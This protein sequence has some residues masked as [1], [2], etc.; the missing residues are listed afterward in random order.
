MLATFVCDSKNNKK[1]KN[2]THLERDQTF[3]HDCFGFFV[4]QIIADTNLKLSITKCFLQSFN[5]MFG[6][7]SI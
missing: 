3:K 6:S 7:S 2:N 1:I 4:G 5:I